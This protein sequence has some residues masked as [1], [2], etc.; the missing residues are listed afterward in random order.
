MFALIAICPLTAGS[1]TA[2]DFTSGMSRGALVAIAA[3]RSLE[4][5]DIAAGSVAMGRR[6]EL[7]VDGTFAFCEDGLYAYNHN[8]DFDVDYFQTVQKLLADYG[9]PTKLATELQS[10]VGPGGG[11]VRSVQLIW[12]RGDDRVTVNVAPEGRDG[13]GALRH[14]R[15][16]SVSYLARSKCSAGQLAKP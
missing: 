2:D 7:R 4:V 1:F 5:W 12:R 11:Y 15:H 10:W 3:S 14:N 13:K 6:S 16:A 8:V 9:Q